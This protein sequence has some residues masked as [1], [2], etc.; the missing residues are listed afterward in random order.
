MHSSKSIWVIK[1]S[2]GQ[3][4]PPWDNHFG[5]STIWSLIY[6]LNYVYLE[7]WP[8]VLYFCSPSRRFL[9]VWQSL[10]W[11]EKKLRREVGFNPIWTGIL[12][13]QSWTGIRYLSP[14]V[15]YDAFWCSCSENFFDMFNFSV[16]QNLTILETTRLI[17]WEIQKMRQFFLNL[18]LWTYTNV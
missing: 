9:R 8:S 3:N 13:C 10:L 15:F 1:L 6:F 14:N 17:H 4:D 5:Q 11:L 7:I 2:F 12:R 16:A 18:N